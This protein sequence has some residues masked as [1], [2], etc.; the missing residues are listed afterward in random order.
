MYNQYL[1][2]KTG[3]NGAGVF[4]SVEIPAGVPI[5]EVTGQ[6]YAEEK[7]PDPNDPALIQVGPN[8]YIGPSGTIDDYI[9]HS[10]NPN[11]LLR[12]VG[13]RAIIHSMYVIRAGSEI[14]FDYSTSSTDT[15][16]KWQMNCNCGS[17]NC[18]KVISG[19]QYLDE[20]LQA[21]YKKKGMIP[22]FLTHPIFTK[23]Y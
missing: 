11:C 23:R 17:V 8:I 19:L 6:V 4:T 10:C 1:T 3:K 22:L 9:G 2:V 7:L 16:D 12:A 20:N 13:S 5:I 14:T 15:L 21:E 18:R